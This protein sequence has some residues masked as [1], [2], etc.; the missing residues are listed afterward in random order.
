MADNMALYNCYIKT[1]VLCVIVLKS[2]WVLTILQLRKTEFKMRT[3]Q[4]LCP[5]GLG[6]QT[7]K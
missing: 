2:T 3:F 4:L 7:L 1:D 6:D 5:I